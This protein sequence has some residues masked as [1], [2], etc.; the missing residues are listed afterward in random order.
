MAVQDFTDLIVALHFWSQTYYHFSSKDAD[1]IVFLS[2]SGGSQHSVSLGEADDSVVGP[3][4]SHD[5]SYSKR[6]S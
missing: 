6:V 2:C 1:Q 3:N 4:F 5:H